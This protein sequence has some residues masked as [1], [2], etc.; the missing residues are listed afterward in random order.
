MAPLPTARLPSCVVRSASTVGGEATHLGV[1]E[2]RHEM[3]VDHPHGLHERVADRGPDEPETV[4]GEGGA[5]PVRLP[6]A[7]R[8]V[9][10]AAPAVLLGPVPYEAPQKD[11]EGALP[12]AKLEERPCVRHGR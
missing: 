10:Q 7:S 2:A 11:V 6:G 9:P 12:L 1:P 3:V 5:H 8:E 4:L